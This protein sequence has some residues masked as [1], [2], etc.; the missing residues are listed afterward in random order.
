MLWII[1]LLVWVPTVFAAPHDRTGWT[2][3]AI[4]AAIACGAWVVADSYRAVPYRSA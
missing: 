2:A 3:L 1:T 4:S